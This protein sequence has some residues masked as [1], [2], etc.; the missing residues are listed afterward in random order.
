MYLLLSVCFWAYVCGMYAYV[1][2][3]LHILYSCVFVRD[4]VT[5]NVYYIVA[6]PLCVLYTYLEEENRNFRQL[7]ITLR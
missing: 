3:F 5:Q 7:N 2:A 4:V 6:G 1:F